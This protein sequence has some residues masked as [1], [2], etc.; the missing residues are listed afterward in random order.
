MDD[1]YIIPMDSNVPPPTTMQEPITRSQV[2]QLNLKVSSFLCDSFGD[3]K[4]N[5]YLMML[6]LLKILER[7]MKDLEK[8]SEAEWTSTGVQVKMEA[9]VQLE[10][11]STSNSRSNLH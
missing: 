9:L 4:N 2:Q 6:L 1:E 11:E 3:Y 8:G 10:L 5:Y 7:I